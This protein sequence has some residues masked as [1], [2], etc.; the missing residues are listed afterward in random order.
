[1][2]IEVKVSPTFSKYSSSLQSIVDL[3]WGNAISWRYIV[4]ITL[5]ARRLNRLQT[6]AAEHKSKMSK[7]SDSK[8]V[9]KQSSFNA[10]KIF[11]GDCG[12]GA[13]DNE[14][15]TSTIS[16]VNGS[17]LSH[18]KVYFT[19][20]RSI[21][22]CDLSWTTLSVLMNEMWIFGG[23]VSTWHIEPMLLHLS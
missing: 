15:T 23:W 8:I 9:R 1:M 7:I 3:W 12:S 21:S 17:S 18:F 10:F 11:C 16:R 19:P 14:L 4:L 13:G 6:L 5:L 22:C 20:S 2:V